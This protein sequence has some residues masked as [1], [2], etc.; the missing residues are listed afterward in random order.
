[1]V[2]NLIPPEVPDV[3]R[4]GSVPSVGGE[5]SP[6]RVVV[7]A[8]GSPHAHDFGP[9]GEALADVLTAA[10]W[11]VTVTA[12]PDEAAAELVAGPAA[13]AGPA[14]ALVVDGLWW[15]ML[16]EAYDRWR[17]DH[18]YSPAA[19]VRA[20][21]TDFVAGGGG[22]VALHTAV[23]C[24][25]DWPGWADLVGA[26]WRWGVSSH[27]PKGPVVARVVADHPVVAG[28]GPELRLHDEVYG[29]LDVAP[30]VDVLAVARRMPE[31]ADQPV[32]WTHR[33]GAGRVVFD[34][35]GHDAASIRHPG[36][37]RLVAQAVAWVARLSGRDAAGGGR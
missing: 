23:I 25:D 5:G 12:T 28:L 37:A 6:G 32:V 11:A 20:A 24:F 4:A 30:G 18:A 33:H 14:E 22:L 10:G 17:P 16:G 29:G 35:F 7:L 19:D 2:A 36:N 15:R 26:S 21:L 34:G 31:D 13:P 27:P 1:M 3:T 9:V 8:G